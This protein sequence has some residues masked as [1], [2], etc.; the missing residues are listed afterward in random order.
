MEIDH[1]TAE[2][3]TG[4]ASSHDPNTASLAAAHLALCSACRASLD[5]LPEEVG[6]R[7]RQALVSGN[8]KTRYSRIDYRRVVDRVLQETQQEQARADRARRAAGK[9]V[10]ELARHPLARRRLVAANIRRFHTWAVVELLLE[11][12]WNAWTRD[13]ELSE[14]CA[15]IACDIVEGLR[16]QGYRQLLLNDLRAEAWSYLGNALR[17]RGSLDKSAQAFE[18]AEEYLA[19]GTGD[20]EEHVQLLELKVPLLREQEKLEAAYSAL[21]HVIESRRTLGDS[22]L[23]GRSLISKAKLLREW[24]RL[25]ESVD[26]L[27]EAQPLIDTVREPSLEYRL[28]LNLMTYLL[29]L[30]RVQQA[31]EFLGRVKLLARQ[32]GSRVE[33]LRALWVEGRLRYALGQKDMGEELLRTVYEGFLKAGVAHESAGVAL[34]LAA[35]YLDLGRVDD[36]RKLAER[37][38]GFALLATSDATREA[39]AALIGL[40]NPVEDLLRSRALI[41]EVARRLWTA[42]SRV[43][44][45]DDL[46]P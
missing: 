4:L 23:V 40:G 17:I 15:L 26:A 16:A 7:V 6:A 34:D 3:L 29:L 14:V 12:S 24:G 42:P 46:P 20:A 8:P 37:V 31:Q 11:D 44:H 33:Q 13:P 10:A 22:H 45:G 5:R 21:E 32:I 25:E 19:R 43:H 38:K 1:L 35:I 41:E 27:L 2:S 28:K 30:G 9:L 39:V 18:T 36:V